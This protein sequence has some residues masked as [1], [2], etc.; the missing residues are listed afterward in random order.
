M[1]YLGLWCKV[2]Q[3]MLCP[4]EYNFYII[5]KAKSHGIAHHFTLWPINKDQQEIP[6]DFV[7]SLL[8]GFAMIAENSVIRL[9]KLHKTAL[10]LLRKLSY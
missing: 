3:L 8:V 5:Y 7:L 10:W 9:W 4:A 6:A 1:F 2:C